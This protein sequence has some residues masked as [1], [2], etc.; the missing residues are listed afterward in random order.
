MLGRCESSQRFTLIFSLVLLL[1]TSACNQQAPDTRIADEAAIRDADAQWSKTAAT[2][3]VDA[4]VAFYTDNASVLPPNASA[5]TGKEAI[6]DV[7]TSLLAPEV[8]SISWQPNKVEVARSG[9]LGYLTGTYEVT[10]KDQKGN[11][12]VDKGKMVEV[13]KKQSDGKWKCVADIFNSDLPASA[14]P[15]T[16]K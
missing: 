9:D 12:V 5:A 2:R 3:D 16:K 15:E 10:E 11:P 6:R 7:W 1:F 8:T 13:W 14:R 4:T